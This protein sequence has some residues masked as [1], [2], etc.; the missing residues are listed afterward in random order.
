MKIHVKG[1]AV[2]TLLALLAAAACTGSE[3]V[4]VGNGINAA[5][6]AANPPVMRSVDG[7]EGWT[8][9]GPPA[10]YNAEG[11]YG[12]I[13]GGAEIVLEY[14]FRE[15]AVFR[16]KPATRPDATNELIL[17]IYRMRSGPAAFGLYSSKLEGG[18]ESMPG[19]NSDNWIGPGQG[20]LVKGDYFV[21]VIAS[22]RT[23]P[24]IGVVLKAVEKKLPA[25]RTVRPEGLAR[26]PRRDMIPSSWRYVRGPL[27]ARNESPFLEGDFWGFQGAA[28]G[29]TR[30]EAF[31]AKFGAAP[32]ISKL[33][34]VE[35]GR[36]VDTAAVDTG[37]SALFAEYLQGV[38]RDGDV[39]E[40]RNRAGR[41]FL[42]K[43]S[44]AV[45]ALVLGET[46]RAA[47]RALAGRAL[48]PDALPS[49]LS[50]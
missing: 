48:V 23:G 15:L 46:D 31:S 47:G 50:P 34:V 40:G 18:E 42:Y 6:A 43:R 21:N 44:G 9:T 22:D 41:W 1:A 13:D 37:V 33:V 16:F 17:E 12:Y 3:A 14:G 26:L 30:S 49:L 24:E 28:S 7:L 25:R 5:A 20:S 35:L 11:L 38:G 29:E 8:R 27:A 32:A 2:P 45:V 19:I 10:R 39:L 4:L 36:A